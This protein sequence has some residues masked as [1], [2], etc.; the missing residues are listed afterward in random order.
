MLLFDFVGL[1]HVTALS[2]KRNNSITGRGITS[3]SGLIHLVE[4]DLERCLKI[5]GGLVH[6]KG[7]YISFLVVN[8]QSVLNLHDFFFIMIRHGWE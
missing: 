1:L 5:H 6:L 3:L 7:C 8:D 2:L 4:L